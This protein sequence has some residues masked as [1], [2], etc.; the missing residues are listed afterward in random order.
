MKMD[1]RELGR[2]NCNK[3]GLPHEILFKLVSRLNCLQVAIYIFSNIPILAQMSCERNPVKLQA[4]KKKKN[5]D[6]RG[7]TVSL[8]T[9][10]KVHDFWI[11]VS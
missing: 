7:R 3:L 9:D 5:F 8:L 4:T 1:K 6:S 2:K 10:V 11:L